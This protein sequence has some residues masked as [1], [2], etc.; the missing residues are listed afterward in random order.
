[1]SPDHWS[2]V[3]DLIRQFGIHPILAVIPD[4]QDL[5]LETSPFNEH[6]WEEVRAMQREGAAIAL[7]GYQHRC[8]S[9]A[10]SLLPLHRRSEFAGH[11]LIEQCSRIRT[12]LAL[13][14]GRGLNPRLFVAPNH[15]FDHV[16]LRALGEEGL[17]YLSDGFARVPFIRDGVT[18]IPQQL[19]GPVRRDK[20]LWTICLHPNAAG[21]RRLN[22]LRHFIKKHG[23]QFTSF[24]KVIERFA[25]ERLSF[26][27]RLHE[28]LALWRVVYRFRR[29]RHRA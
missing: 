24:D 16:T 17:P 6:F 3:R 20:G 9:R 25:P 5:D 8:T 22:E 29:Q 28:R 23:D 27:E 15:S 14:R 12:G 7:H 21:S 26:V 11:P 13:L 18:W 1:V 2:G 19:W 10:K 4:N